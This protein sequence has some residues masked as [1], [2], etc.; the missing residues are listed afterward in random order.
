MLINYLFKIFHLLIYLTI[1][2]QV[3]AK[4]MELVTSM[5]NII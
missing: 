1:I 5:S 2:H 3:L 4:N